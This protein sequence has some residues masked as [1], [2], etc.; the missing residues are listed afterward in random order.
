ML[1]Q[2]INKMQDIE[3]KAQFKSD[4]AAISLKFKKKK[5]RFELPR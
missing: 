3:F 5:T 2:S 4:T 1:E